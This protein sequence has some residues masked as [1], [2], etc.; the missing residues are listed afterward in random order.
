MKKITTLI[1]ALVAG[2]SVN[3]AQ[4]GCEEDWNGYVESKDM[5]STGYFTLYGG[6]EKMVSQAYHYSGTGVITAV[7]F[8]YEHYHW[9]GYPVRVSIYYVDANNKPT[10]SPIVQTNEIWLGWGQHTATVGLNNKQVTQ[11]FAIVVERLLNYV[12]INIKHTDGDGNGE[13]LAASRTNTGNWQSIGSDS[14]FFIK[15]K[16]VHE[17]DPSFTVDSDCVPLNTAVNF[18]NASEFTQDR[19][20]NQITEPGYSGGEMLYSWD[21]GDGGNSNSENPS[22]TFTS[23]GLY[24]VTLTTTIDDW[25]GA[26]C[27]NTYSMEI[28]VG[29]DVTA[30]SAD[31]SCYGAEN[32]SLTLTG[33]GGDG[34][35][36]YSL[37]GMNYDTPS[38]FTG[39]GA[40]THNIYVMDGHGC[41]S[42]GMTVTIAEPAEIII[43]SPVGTT[44]AT[45]G[46]PDGGITA[47]ASGGEGTLNY[48][49]D[50]TNYQS[51]G[52]FTGLS[53][54]MYT[55]YVRDESN[56]CVETETVVVSNTNSPTLTLQSYT[57]IACYGET[58]GTITVIGS[59]GT[60][61]LEY[62]LDGTTFQSTGSFTG[63][64]A[65]SYKP[66]VRDAAGCIGT[67]GTI[68]ITQ[69]APIKW[70]LFSTAALCNGSSDG[71]VNVEYYSGGIGTIT[72]SIDGTNFQQSS[73][74]NGLAAG[75]YTITTKDGA[76]CTQTANIMVGEPS[77]VVASVSSTAD[78]S[79]H[80]SGDGSITVSANGGT[81]GYMFRLQNWDYQNSNVFNELS[82]GTYTVTVKDN[83][84]CLATTSVTIAQPTEILANITSGN[85]T[86][87]NANG[88][89]LV[90]GSGGS[91]SGYMYDLNDG[92]Q[93]N[94]TG[95]FSGLPAD[96]YG[97][98]ITDGTGCNAFFG[99]VVTDSDGPSIDATASTDVTCNGGNDG[100]ISI[101][102]V[103]GG[104]GTLE[105]SVDGEDYQSSNVFTDLYAGDHTVR[106]RD[107]NGCT[108]E[109]SITLTEP[110]GISVVLTGTDVTC[111]GGYSGE[112]SVAAG[113]GA[114]TLAYSSNG[115]NYQSTP[116]FSGLAAGTYEITV[117]DAGQCTS[118]EEITITQPTQ[119]VQYSGSLNV[120]C[121]GGTDGA[122]YTFANGGTGS[123]VYS[124][125]GVNYQASGVFNNLPAGLYTVYAKDNNDCIVYE[126]INITEPTALNLNASVVNVSCASGENG[127]IDLTVIGG[128]APYTYS[129]TGPS[130]YNSEDIFNL[131]SGTYN[132]TVTDANG[133]MITSGYTVT[134]PASPVIVNGA[135]T[136]AS[137]QTN[138]DGAIDVTATGGTP[139]YTYDWDNGS[140]QEDLSSLAPGVYVV[141]V[142][143][144]AGCSNSAYFTVGATTG[145]D[146]ENGQETIVVYPNP[147]NDFIKIEMPK[148]SD[149][150][151][152]IDMTGKVIYTAVP[153]NT[154]FQLQVADLSEG[155][156]FI[157]VYSD[158][159]VNRIK[160]VINR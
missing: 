155:V 37:D 20:F 92:L 143:D 151:E 60:G 36:E 23:A 128:T 130:F 25:E 102:G 90:V 115:I 89:L 95:A 49:L 73:V 52:S 83:H 93:T 6:A 119:I 43:A 76:G 63:L 134:E 114:G 10:G 81:P 142:T 62:S 28:S 74:F 137:S 39:L 14:D 129:W 11:D 3:W 132:V 34:T 53:A 64:A 159:T 156:Y 99:T 91:G 125:D 100:T 30:T 51:T 154:K 98:M 24:N 56:S 67:V 65:G 79:C 5:G 113:G 9:W 141:E 150:I 157:N 117:K 40:G 152:M 160:V 144:A 126:E 80:E 138:T 18:T 38:T 146:E 123:K 118:T 108:G 75:T 12:P 88:T 1:F 140:T 26:P 147:A 70:D 45:C 121:S 139:P 105:Y 72:Y 17:N 78:L 47:F 61:S 84:N 86:C 48:S 42:S 44:S 133:C 21:F 87:G 68:T 116:V 109:V 153:E 8:E 27:Q 104:T 69:P 122:I 145:L 55:L 2:I 4:T 16:M 97:V 41:E 103:S 94:G 120:T 13:D 59:G 33:S 46:N 124:I 82:A 85:S 54:G 77:V 35:Y 112:I 136:N 135:V 107:A 148:P 19:M 131:E 158:G 111:Y 149:K 7:Q 22:H 110:A 15:P 58:N 29:L 50:N 31:V 96:E 57:T 101:T 71:Q 32:G 106:V 66:I 127:V